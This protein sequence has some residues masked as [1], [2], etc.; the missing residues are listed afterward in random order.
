MD[1]LI[2][3]S[4]TGSYNTL[5]GSGAT[6]PSPTTSNAFVLGTA[7]NTVYMGGAQGGTTGV[8]VSSTAITLKGSTA[9]VVGSAGLTGQTLLS[10]GPNAPPYWS[11]SPVTLEASPLDL[12]A[13]TKPPSI[14]ILSNTGSAFMLYLPAANVLPNAQITIKNVSATQVVTVTSRSG[15]SNIVDLN[16]TTTT[17]SINIAAGASSLIASNGIS[18]YVLS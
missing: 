10:G 2:I 11:P 7:A 8:A 12:T 18:W 13:T 1:S 16:A 3:M 6:L 4:I 14:L 17:G 9:L 5:I 15:V